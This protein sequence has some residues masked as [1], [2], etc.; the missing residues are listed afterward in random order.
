MY[1]FIVQKK[2]FNCISINYQVTLFV[3]AKGGHELPTIYDKYDLKN[4]LQRL[5]FIGSSNH[6]T[7]RLKF[8]SKSLFFFFTHTH[9]D[10]YIQ[11]TKQGS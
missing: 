5:I 4:V 3:G 9:I 6:I 7:V 10:I 8:S 1:M 2:Y 11:A